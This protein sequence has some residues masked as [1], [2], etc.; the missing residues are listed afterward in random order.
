VDGKTHESADFAHAGVRPLVAG[1]ALNASLLDAET[2]SQSL[3]F[4]IHAV[5]HGELV[6]VDGI[7]VADVPNPGFA[8][9]IL[10]PWRII[11]HLLL[12]DSHC[13]FANPAMS[14]GNDGELR[15]AC[16]TVSLESETRS[17]MGGSPR[18]C[19]E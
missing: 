2:A 6:L 19:G 15:E 12:E 3:Q 18:V 13:V 9:G 4:G 8:L 16:K 11:R 1:H 5:A 7:F 10:L 17:R 14:P